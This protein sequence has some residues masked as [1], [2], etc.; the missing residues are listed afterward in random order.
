MKSSLPARVLRHRI[1]P[2][3]QV[4][5]RSGLTSF[6]SSQVRKGE[7]AMPQ[8]L[9]I[10]CL[11]G[12][13]EVDLREALIP[14]GVSEI[15]IVAVLGSVE[16]FVPPGVRVEMMVDGFVGSVEFLPDPTLP[17]LADSPVLRIRGNAYFA[18]VEVFVRYV[19]ESARE[20][21]KRI[22]ESW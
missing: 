1:L 14:E 11:L 6:M 8:H 13:A 21:K 2:T 22:K 7:W 19:G 5:E 15:E 12:S 3:A 4:R 18:S 10:A 9:R 17:S 20:A 16:I